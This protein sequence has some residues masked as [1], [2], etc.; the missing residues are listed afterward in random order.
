[1]PVITY[2]NTTA[3][4]KAVSDICCTS[5]NAIKVVERMVAQWGVDRVILLPDEYPLARYVA[6]RPAST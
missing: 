3:E 2:V 6:D 4:V 5:G 1:M